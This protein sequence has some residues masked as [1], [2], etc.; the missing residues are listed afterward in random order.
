[1]PTSVE[2]LRLLQV[3]SCDGHVFCVNVMATKREAADVYVALL[4]CLG[5]EDEAQDFSYRISIEKKNNRLTWEGTPASARRSHDDLLEIGEYFSVPRLME[6]LVK[7]AEDGVSF[8]LKYR[9][10]RRR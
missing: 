7:E 3:L 5:E 8:T 9:V 1:M 6:S 2:V 10:R 4:Q